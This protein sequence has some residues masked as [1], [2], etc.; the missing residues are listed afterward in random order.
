MTL[1]LAC[2][3]YSLYSSN[4]QHWLLFCHPIVRSLP[5]PHTITIIINIDRSAKP[6]SKHAFML[7]SCCLPCLHMKFNKMF[8][9]KWKQIRW[10]T[11]F[12]KVNRFPQN[13]TSTCFLGKFLEEIFS[14]SQFRRFLMYVPCKVYTWRGKNCY[15]LTQLFV[16]KIQFIFYFESQIVQ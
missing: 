2:L 11:Y 7:N 13:F 15:F 5:A 3:A 1:G 10:K 4:F 16:S 14:G 6:Q 8:R 12:E 9:E